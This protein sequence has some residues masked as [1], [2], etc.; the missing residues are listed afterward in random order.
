MNNL[1]EQLFDKSKNF[2]MGIFC[3]YSM[4]LEFF[5][6]YLLKLNGIASC[7]NLCVFT[8]R[9]IYNS[10]FN[11]NSTSKPKWINKR[12][13]LIPVDTKGVFHPKLYLLASDKV[14]MIGIGS[15]NL[16]REG[17][18]NNLE[19]ESVFEI[20]EK[21]RT[22]SGILK[23]CINFL[24]DI[25]IIS[26][27][28][29]ALES[30]GAFI[31][32]TSHLIESEQ[33]SSVHLIHNLEE[34][35]LPRVT[36]EL[37][38]CSVE[39]IRIISPFYDK[40]LE[41]QRFLKSVYN[42]ANFTIYIQQGKSNF[43][44]ENYN[45]NKDETKIYLYKDQNRYIHGKAI[46][47]ETDKG[48]YLL[49][50][51]TNYTKS[52][53]LSN[54]LKANIEIAIFSEIDISISKEL[55]KP[56]GIKAIE[57][58][59]IQKLL[60]I[61]NDDKND[62]NNDIIENCLVEV[63]YT[64]KHLEIS[65]IESHDLIPKYI[66]INGNSNKRIKYQDIINIKGIEKSELTNA[67]IEGIDKNNQNINSNKVW[68]VNLNKEFTDISKKR[69]TINDPSQI[70][71]ILKDLVENGSEE[72]LI[73]Y[74]LKFNIPVDLVVFNPMGRGNGAILSKGNIFGELMQQSKS[75][76]KNPKLFEAVQ[77]FLENNMDK[78]YEHYD[79][80][81]L[82]KLDNFM[83]IYGT[84]F[85]MM[86]FFDDYI[87]KHYNRNPI[88]TED[89]AMIRN[90][91]DIMLK[92]IEKVLYLLWMPQDYLSFEEQV[93]QEI[94]RDKQRM[95][96]EISSFKSFIVNR[97]YENQYESSLIISQKIISHLGKYVENTRVRTVY[98]TIVKAQVAKNGMNDNY[99]NNKENILL[100]VR[101]LLKIFKTWEI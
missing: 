89:W 5:E 97:D 95:L 50:G 19:I 47:F 63:L 31:N 82:N 99:I 58:K 17:L 54:N 88:D 72:E 52:A 3:T 74:L 91:Y 6:N 87:T 15:A 100:Y 57:L 98:D 12:Y 51:S 73:A 93:N 28:P 36:K 4:N 2:Q 86:N 26:H 25:A 77:Y 67:Y 14:V 83:L 65:L 18:S 78:L 20:S 70:I 39:H 35:I 22:H 33:N 7:S 38:N 85:N 13:L 41:V 53:L 37:S 79:N 45:Y 46:I 76:F 40:N 68:I 84:L 80:L 55:C 9:S 61:C 29:S 96:G 60:V 23:E 66:V 69:V 90:Y 21:D 16:T 24:H 43:P 71:L 1:V 59:D 75:K 34:S 48:T 92:C 44:V 10:H 27:S 81:Q 8:D 32:F 49:T 101:C 94:K 62:V 30:I 64:D 42:S 56:G 11:I